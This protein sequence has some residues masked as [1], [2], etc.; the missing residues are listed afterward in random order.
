MKQI[1]HYIKEIRSVEAAGLDGMVITSYGEVSLPPA[2]Q[3]TKID[4]SGLGECSEE[5]SVENKAVIHSV[6]LTARILSANSLRSGGRY[7]Y[8]LICVDGSRWLLGADTH[9]Y[10]KTLVNSVMPGAPTESSADTLTVE[11]KSTFGLLKVL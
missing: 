4:I 7:A 5:T 2:L 1:L 8:I 3:S 9:P 11:Y 10:P 6:K